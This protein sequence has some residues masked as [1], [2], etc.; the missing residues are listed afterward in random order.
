M[1]EGFKRVSFHSMAKNCF[2]GDRFAGGTVQFL[3][4]DII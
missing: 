1:L 2:D 4:D 3:V